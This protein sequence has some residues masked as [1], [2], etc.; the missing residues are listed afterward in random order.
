MALNSGIA[1][2]SLRGGYLYR[3]EWRWKGGTEREL[4]CG[5]VP[6]EII[7]GQHAQVSF[8]FLT[9]G[10]QGLLEDGGLTIKCLY[11]LSYFLGP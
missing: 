2:V 3:G 9:F 6:A 10:F 1:N 11:Q 7:V 5:M 4:V 8:P